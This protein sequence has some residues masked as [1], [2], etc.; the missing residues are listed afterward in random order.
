[1]SVLF[2]LFV[3]DHE[4][5]KAAQAQQ[6]AHRTCEPCTQAVCDDNVGVGGCFAVEALHA[7]RELLPRSDH[8]LQ[9]LY[10]LGT[11]GVIEEGVGL[12]LHLDLGIGHFLLLFI[13]EQLVVRGVRCQVFH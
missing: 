13:L 4:G 11:V 10:I 1:M 9:L 6:A 12:V 8:P 3:A 2:A 5:H 7:E